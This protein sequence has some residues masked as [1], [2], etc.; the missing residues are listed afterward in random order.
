ME[1]PD[2]QRPDGSG[3]SERRDMV[4]H[5][6]RILAAAQTLFAEHDVDTVSMHQIALAAGVGQG[7]LYRRFAHKGLLCL[8]L[9]D[10]RIV[11][12]QEELLA[13]LKQ[14]DEARPA[15]AL[16]DY[17]LM[18]L[19]AFNEDNASL[20]G[21]IDDAAC[22]ERRSH[23]YQSPFYLWLYQVVQVLLRRAVARQEIPEQDSDYAADLILAPL[24]IDFYLFQRRVRGLTQQ[25]IRAG[26][27]QFL[28]H[29]LGAHSAI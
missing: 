3:Q 15:L 27:Q 16:L 20:L 4:E 9:L 21:G 13:Y 5:R 11:H 7:T 19:I 24:A 18:Q 25:Q 14:E 12:F 17:V 8:A 26:L 6:R 28:H 1:F 2:V 23:A 29:G 22:G 10:E